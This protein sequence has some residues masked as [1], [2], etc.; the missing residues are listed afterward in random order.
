MWGFVCL[1]GWLVGFCC[2]LSLF[3]QFRSNS[4]CR[5]LIGYILIIL[6]VCAY[7]RACVRA[8]AH[9]SVRVFLLVCVVLFPSKK[10]SPGESSLLSESHLPSSCFS[11]FA[12]FQVEGASP[13][14]PRDAAGCFCRPWE[15][16]WSLLYGEPKRSLP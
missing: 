5:Y 13:K 10:T 1:V 16:K 15:P 4:L 8:C 12:R 6:S 3:A 14:T 2:C 11:C 9:A 7:V